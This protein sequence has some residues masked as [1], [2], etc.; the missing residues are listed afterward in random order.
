MEKRIEALEQRLAFVEGQLACAVCVLGAFIGASHGA[1]VFEKDVLQN[2]AQSNESADQDGL[3]S[4]PHA[5][6]W[7]DALDT[8]SK[9]IGVGRD[10]AISPPRGHRY[11]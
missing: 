7:S 11:F 8:V 1:G 6:G 10:L 3:A 5:R 2:F 9:M 4:A